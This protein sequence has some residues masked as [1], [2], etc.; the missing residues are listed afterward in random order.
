MRWR[1]VGLIAWV[2]IAATPPGA[3]QEASAPRSAAQRDWRATA[4]LSPDGAVRIGSPQAKVK[5]AEYLS[6]TCPHCADFVTQ[7]EPV[8][9]D[10]MV[11]TGRVQVEY[12]H[13]VRDRLDLASAL[14]ARCQGPVGFAAANKAIFAA[15]PA[16]FARTQAFQ[17][18]PDAYK[19]AATLGDQLIR[20]GEGSGLIALL[21]PLGLSGAKARACLNNQAETERLIKM[22]EAVAAQLEGTPSF[23]INGNFV[24]SGSWS[25]LEPQLRAAG[26]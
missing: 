25:S 3:A 26:A 21:R 15:Q 14:L 9:K 18:R 4:T 23:A 13:F 5:L 16:T 6:Y 10:Q 1:H 7:S 11:R 17:A 12:R 2:A 22:T 20:L 19:G 24:G 8:L